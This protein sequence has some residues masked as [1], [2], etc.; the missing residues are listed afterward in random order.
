MFASLQWRQNEGDGVSNLRR[1]DICLSVRSGADQR[2]YQSSASLAYVKGIHRSPRAGNAEKVSI[3]WRHHDIK[4]NANPFLIRAINIS[5]GLFLYHTYHYQ[6]SWDPNF[7]LKQNDLKLNATQE[8]Q[9]GFTKTLNMA[10][11]LKIGYIRF[12]PQPFVQ[13]QIKEIIKAPCHWPL[14]GESTGDGWIP[15]NKG[16]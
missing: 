3:W 9:Q 4:L 6:W 2:K 12:F 7:K 8:K 14:R 15:L 10:K 13:A 11:P 16:Q 5:S 1:L